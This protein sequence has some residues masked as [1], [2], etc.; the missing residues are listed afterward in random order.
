MVLLVPLWKVQTAS[1]SPLSHSLQNRSCL[2]ARAVLLSLSPWMALEGVVQFLLLV[3][4]RVL[5]LSL[6]F[7]VVG[8]DRFRLL[9][10]LE[11]L[12]LNQM[13]LVEA[14][15]SRLLVA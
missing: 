2:A 14:P 1:G 3:A 12:F 5:F 9:V 10:A 15:R 13:A 6:M 4:L 8:V 7:K 11:V